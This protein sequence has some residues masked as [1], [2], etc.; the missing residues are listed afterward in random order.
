M[1]QQ[2]RR[3][4]QRSAQ[5]AAFFVHPGS[6]L[7]FSTNLPLSFGKEDDFTEIQKKA[8]VTLLFFFDFKKAFSIN[9]FPAFGNSLDDHSELSNQVIGKKGKPGATNS[10]RQQR[11]VPVNSR[12]KI[13][14]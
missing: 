3:T 5:P 4:R 13:T 10:I 12:S 1:E 14:F 11:M 8:M 2:L 7:N 6:Y 9:N